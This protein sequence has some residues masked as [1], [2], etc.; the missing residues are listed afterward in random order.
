MSSTGC[1]TDI[2][3]RVSVPVSHRRSSEA[4]CGRKKRIRGSMRTGSTQESANKGTS[5]IYKAADSPEVKGMTAV[6]GGLLES[7][8][9][10]RWDRKRLDRVEMQKV[11]F[12]HI[13]LCQGNRTATHCDYRS[14][15][16]N[17]VKCRP[18]RCCYDSQIA[19]D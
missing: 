8:G 11:T 10:F 6:E 14:E 4:C 16:P 13:S 12:H 17:G 1:R 15:L 3:N 7:F 2:T 9:S 19:G 5:C 18:H